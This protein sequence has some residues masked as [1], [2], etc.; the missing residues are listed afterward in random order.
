MAAAMLGATAARADWNERGHG[1]GHNRGH[2][3][4]HDRGDHRGCNHGS[5]HWQHQAVPVAPAAMHQG[6]Y[7]LQTVQRWVDGHYEQ[8]WVAPVC[9]GRRHWLRCT[10]GGYENV[11]VP[12]RYED[13][14]EW[15]W[16]AF[17]PPT[18]G[19]FHATIRF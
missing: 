18:Q 15:V 10:A 17:G 3:R 11:W 14:Q 16:V 9:T 8:T 4:G 19:Q 12:G 6:R 5:Q 7:E 1:R 2:Q 13:R